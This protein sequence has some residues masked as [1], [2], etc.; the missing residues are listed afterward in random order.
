[1]T[2]IGIIGAGEVGSQSA[3]AAIANGYDV[4]I[5]NS[6]GPE[7]LRDLIDAPGPGPRRSGGRLRPQHR[8]PALNRPKFA[9]SRRETADAG[10]RVRGYASLAGRTG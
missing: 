8:R 4:V 3:R 9:G 10:R 2:V 5:A 1:M 6:R 7:T